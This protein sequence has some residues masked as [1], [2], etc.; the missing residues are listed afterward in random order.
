MYVTT[1][2][3]F[4]AQV[5]F[6][7]A[8]FSTNNF[9]S[10]TFILCTNQPFSFTAL[11]RTHTHKSPQAS[12]FV[13]LLCFCVF[14]L[15]NQTSSSR[16]GRCPA[17]PQ[18]GHEYH[19]LVFAEILPLRCTATRWGFQTPRCRCSNRATVPTDVPVYNSGVASSVTTTAQG[20]CA[21]C[22]AHAKESASALCLLTVSNQMH[23]SGQSRNFASVPGG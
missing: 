23:S 9:I 18:P 13:F 20:L 3:K 21:V 14:V 19:G 11:T 8:L 22:T 2:V 10:K 17:L 1:D 6:L 7:E 12:V 16:P 5:H 15:S 4:A